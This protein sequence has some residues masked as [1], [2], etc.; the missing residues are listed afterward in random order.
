MYEDKEE[1]IE[2]SF[3][4][5]PIYREYL[6]RTAILQSFA[7]LSAKM[8]RPYISL[9]WALD[10][11][12]DLALIF[13]TTLQDE[14]FV[15]KK[16]NG[17]VLFDENQSDALGNIKSINVNPS[18]REVWIEG[19]DRLSEH[20]L[21]ICTAFEILQKAV[22]RSPLSLKLTGCCDRI[23]DI[24]SL[25]RKLELEIQL[26]YAQAEVSTLRSANKTLKKKLKSLQKRL[27]SRR[28]RTR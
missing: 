17:F 25:E 4:E 8:A 2:S 24:L 26:R 15:P 9:Q 14:L 11:L 7:A 19:L 1:D 28:S 13:G 22:W 6:E 16:T 27:Y 21:E 20:L 10:C 3:C 12:R 23:R 18:V 5:D